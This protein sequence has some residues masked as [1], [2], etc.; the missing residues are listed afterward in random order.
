[1]SY[2]DYLQQTGI[3]LFKGNDTYW[4]VYRGSLIP[5]LLVPEFVGVDAETVGRLLNE[6]RAFLMRW[7]SHPSDQET[8]WWWT[9][10]DEYG[11]SLLSSKMRN[12]IKRGYKEC[13]TRRIPAQWLAGFGYECYAAAFG[14]YGHATP[15]SQDDFK[16][17]ILRKADYESVFQ[18]WGVFV[19]D[20]LVGYT[21]C[22]VEEGKGVVTSVIKYDPDYLRHY[23]SYAMMDTLMGH[24]VTERG[25]PMNNGTRSISHDTNMQDFLLKFGFR[26]RYCRLN[27]K[28]RR[29]VALAIM[30][31][32]PFRK[33]L[34]DWQAGHSIRALL[35]QEELRRECQ[36]PTT[37][38]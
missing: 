25:L 19:M 2:I 21:E 13:S 31:L 26:R 37:K 22:V 3:P 16:A 17:H 34:P 4:R 12:Q 9:V 6:S 30:L 27:V 35:F 1:M 23:P 36:Q 28:Y 38:R 11:L 7:S 33:H 14:R 18:Y 20:R 15:A 29:P 32:Y 5:A 24:Y 10:C 8:P